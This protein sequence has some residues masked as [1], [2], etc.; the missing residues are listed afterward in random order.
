MILHDAINNLSNKLF[1]KLPASL[2]WALVLGAA[3]QMGCVGT[4]GSEVV[5]AGALSAAPGHVNFGDVTTGEN[6]TR[7]VTLSNN[8]A[9]DI[10]ISNL[11]VAGSGFSASGVPSG[12]ILKQGETATLS[13]TFSP[14]SSGDVT[15]QVLMA[16]DAAAEALE[17]SLSGKGVSQGAHSATLSWNPSTSTVAGYRVYRSNTS[18][19]PYTLLNSA[20]TPSTR[21]TDSTLQTGKIYYYVVAAVTSGNVE[22]AYSNQVS[23]AP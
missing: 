19:G 23:A 21:Y 3:L 10:T 12:L 20:P 16:S 22:S 2:L 15:G 11:S 1:S 7:T 5:S 9:P 18:G 14:A 17:I 4:T 6:S 8:G 13:V